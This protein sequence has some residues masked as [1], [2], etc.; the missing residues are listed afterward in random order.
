MHDR[1]TIDRELLI[2]ILV[3]GFSVFG[4]AIVLLVGRLNASRASLPVEKTETPFK[5]IYLGTEPGILTVSPEASEPESSTGLPLESPGPVPTSVTPT[6]V[7]P[8]LVTPGI[9]TPTAATPTLG[10][11]NNTTFPTSTSASVAPLGAGTYDDVDSHLIYDGPWWIGRSGVAGAHQG[12]LHVSEVP[13]SV[14]TFRF[15]GRELRLFYQGA[16]SLGQMTI[17]IDNQTFTLSQSGGSEWV[18]GSL[19]NATHSVLI[20]HVS[21]GAVNL[22][23]VIVPEVSNTATPS[24]TPTR[25][26]PSS[27]SNTR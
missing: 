20:T 4:I 1:P 12:T 27:S 22:D 21:G 17:T 7:T 8:G 3:G 23:Y 10:T 9:I 25:T 6:L 14:L 5:Y 15:I 26:Q 24:A 2:P 11:P 16:A 13:G 19:A 18:S